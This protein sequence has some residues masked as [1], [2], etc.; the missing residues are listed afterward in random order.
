MRIYR[1]IYIDGK[2]SVKATLVVRGFEEAILNQSDYPTCTK[3]C[4]R[5]VV[6]VLIS[7][8]WRYKGSISTR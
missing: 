3:E 8:G 5:L 6:K 1:D 2:K 4:L 7:K